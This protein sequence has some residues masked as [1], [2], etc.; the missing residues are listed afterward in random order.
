MTLNRY[1][2]GYSGI[3]L[4]FAIFYAIVHTVSAPS[5]PQENEIAAEPTR[6]FRAPTPT[7]TV[8][9]TVVPSPT[10]KPTIPAP[11]SPTVPSAPDTPFPRATLDPAVRANTSVPK[12]GEATTE[13][14]TI[15]D[16]P[17]PTIAPSAPEPSAATGTSG[18][19]TTY[20]DIGSLNDGDWIG[21]GFMPRDDTSLLGEGWDCHLGGFSDGTLREMV[22]ADNSVIYAPVQPR[23]D[24]ELTLCIGHGE[25]PDQWEL[26]LGGNRPETGTCAGSHFGSPPQ[27]RREGPIITASFI[28]PA[29]CVT[30]DELVLAFTGKSN[31]GVGLWGI[32][33]RQETTTV[34]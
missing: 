17:Q 4:M 28:I 2:Y 6:V 7:P 3:F 16:P 18:T 13:A 1:L 22:Q 27:E 21:E 19:T 33:V 34:P 5:M 14:P 11:V 31:P 10:P 8:A 20:L 25:T 32:L 30:S 29:E 24:V 12:P 23:L 9:P 26:W 15:A